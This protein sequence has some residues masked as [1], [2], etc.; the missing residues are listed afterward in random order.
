[1]AKL[2]DFIN[3]FILKK[4]ELEKVNDLEKKLAETKKVAD[5]FNSAMKKKKEED[6]LEKITE[7][8]LE[9]KNM[10]LTSNEIV[11]K[12]HRKLNGNDDK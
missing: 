1:M 9:C 12:L 5:E 8:F 10:G 4:A 3:K 7:G 6:A 11:A 2:R